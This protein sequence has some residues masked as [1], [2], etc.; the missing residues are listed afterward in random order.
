LKRRISKNYIISI[1]LLV[2]LTLPILITSQTIGEQNNADNSISIHDSIF[3][4]ILKNPLRKAIDNPLDDPVKYSYN[5]IT[6]LKKAGDTFTI[7]EELSVEHAKN[8]TILSSG[9]DSYNIEDPTPDYNHDSLQYNITSIETTTE[10]ITYETA[11]NKVR[12]LDSTISIRAHSFTVPYTYT[13]FSGAW[14]YLSQYGGSFGTDELK[15]SLVEEDISGFPNMGNI[16]SNEIGGPYNS[17][18]NITTSSSGNPAYYD[19]EDVILNNGVTYFVVA[20]LTF[21]DGDDASGFTWIAKISSIYSNS[22]YYDGI[23]NG[24][25]ADNHGLNFRV[26]LMQS[27]INGDPFIYSDPTTINLQDNGVPITSLTQ[28]IS[29]SGLHTLT[30]DATVVLRFTNNYLFSRTFLATSSFT[31]LNSTHSTYTNHWEI[32]WSLAALDLETYSYINPIR[33]QY[34]QTPSDW[35]DT[36]FTTKINDSISIPTL[37]LSSGYSLSLETIKSGYNFLRG[38][39]NFTTYSPNYLYDYIL[40]DDFIETNEFNLG[41][42][43]TNITHAI[44]YNGSIINAEIF[45]KDSAFSDILTGS[46]N[47]TLYDPYGKIIPV[48]DESDY[49]S[50][51]FTDVTSYT[52]LETTQV[53]AGKYSLTTAFDPS[54][55]GTDIEGYWTAVFLWENGTEIG[56]YSFRIDVSKSTEA[57]FNWEETLGGNDFT[58]S[59]ISID[60]INQESVKVQIL[61]SNISDPFYSGEGTPIN[62][63]SVAYNTSWGTSGFLSYVGPYYETDIQ[64]NAVAGN[65]SVTLTATGISLEAHA[66]T[67]DVRVFHTFE[68]SPSDGG[69]FEAYYNDYKSY[70]QFTVDD[71]SNSSNT[72]IPDEMVFYL[73]DLLLVEEVEY[74]VSEIPDSNLTQLELF[75][76]TDRLDILNGSHLIRISVAKQGFIANYSQENATT[77]VNLEILTT[78]TTIDIV[79]SD[80][81]V[82]WGNE[83]TIT[84]YYV[85]TI[86][87]DNIQEASLDIS[88]DLD[89]AEAEIIGTPSETLGLYSVTVRIYEPQETSINIFLSIRR[90]GY[91]PISD[92]LIKSISIVAPGSEE[93]IPNYI[94]I[95]IG[96]FSLVAVVTPLTVVVRRKLDKERRAEKA[97]FARIYGLYESVLSIT[98]LIIVHKATGL[99]VYEMDLGS[100][101]SLD[102]SLITGFLTAIASMGVELRD[103]KAGSIRRL[104]YKNFSITGSESGQFTLY[105]FSETD[106]NEEIEGQLTVI[107]KWFAKM[108]SNIT[109]DWDGSTEAFRINLKG[110]TEKIMKEIHLWIFY[111]FTVSP[112]KQIEI[113]ELNGLRKRLIEYITEGDNV[114]ISRIFD[115]LDYVKIEKGLPI[116]FEFI[117]NGIL[118]PIFDAYKIATVRF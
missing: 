2:N 71:T 35:K 27:D 81:E 16:L 50:I 36:D 91:E 87:T 78:P 76:N 8:L 99:P 31:A 107:S 11:E 94:Y 72:V 47:F 86:H 13:L 55:N 108:F 118:I 88:L 112:Y 37:R 67:F 79:S 52:I 33:Q 30:A 110:I 105:T 14:I 59:S 43:A 5:T 92:Q 60:R 65:Y 90:P 15:L 56:F 58:N 21:I 53:S 109:E 100:E 106:L 12:D 18:N 113:E 97:L 45:V 6:N 62:A 63:A 104:Q 64:I 102:P 82:Y 77:T 39:M 20:E 73:D 93:G 114:T 22:Y 40:T 23:W 9:S 19:F 66:I 70:I 85:D 83:T 98:K 10:Q 57:S 49:T 25:N 41:Y 115:E 89:P 32:V 75:S 1:L 101:I 48:K 69:N 51:S 42:W 34:F 103:D 29:T 17:S 95:I 84:F 3:N 54:I 24:P 111:P 117:E 46:V 96:I 7:N 26:E 68:I 80:D 61:Y 116:I 4:S 38:E 44:G 28:S 74:N